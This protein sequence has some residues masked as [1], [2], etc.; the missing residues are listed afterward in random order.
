MGRLHMEREMACDE[1]VVDA[2]GSAKAYATC[3]ARVASLGQASRGSHLAVAMLSSH[4]LTRRVMR[5]LA[6][7]R[8]PAF[9]PYWMMVPAAL[10]VVVA[11]ATGQVSL[12]GVELAAVRAVGTR[13]LAMQAPASLP[14]P[15]TSPTGATSAGAVR[16]PRPAA[17]PRQSAIAPRPALAP[18][19]PEHQPAPVD[20]VAAT[21]PA[22]VALAATH[23]ADPAADAP[24]DAPAASDAP[25]MSSAPAD[26]GA[27]AV[28]APASG[29][30][31][32]VPLAPII[33]GQAKDTW[34]AATRAGESIG[35]TSRK[36]AVATAGFVTRLRKKVATSF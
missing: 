17:P 18:Q 16:T 6:R 13:V 36:T 32:A 29:A 1:V 31:A 23:A 28:S 26:P 30:A 8:T 22:A 27:G 4:G 7:R 9:A 3:L 12:V 34:A 35:L 21:T 15:V 11:I 25:A 2:T 19:T 20:V 24:R 33:A 14:S 10:A 5:L